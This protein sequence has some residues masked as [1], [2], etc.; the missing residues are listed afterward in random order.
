MLAVAA[1][2]GTVVIGILQGVV[3][4]IAL[5]LVEMLYRLARPH[6]GVL[7]RVPGVDGMHDVADYSARTIPGCM[8]YR[9]DAPL[10][11]ANI[12]DLRERVDKLIAIERDAYPDSPL[13]WFVLNV[14]AN[15]EFEHR[16][17][18]PARTGPG[19]W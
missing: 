16:G 6:E 18:W 4:A 5:S 15:V 12:G 8:F 3:L 17:R 7:G 11:F 19:A 9:H 1:L 10:F 2:V 13:Q 14:E